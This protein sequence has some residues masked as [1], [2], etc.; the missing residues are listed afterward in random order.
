M[1]DERMSER[2]EILARIEKLR[3]EAAELEGNIP[4]HSTSIGHIARIEG[5]EDEIE[6]LEGELASLN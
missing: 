6:V 5:L 2:D 3:A 1:R 4:A